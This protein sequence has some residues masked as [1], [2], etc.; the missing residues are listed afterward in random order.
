MND[1]NYLADFIWFSKNKHVITYLYAL[2][3]KRSQY[4]QFSK[5]F[6]FFNISLFL[7]MKQQNISIK[8]APPIPSYCSE[9]PDKNF[10]RSRQV[11]HKA[12]TMLELMRLSMLAKAEKSVQCNSMLPAKYGFAQKYGMAATNKAHEGTKNS[13]YLRNLWNQL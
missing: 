4:S 8:I 5:V 3:L 2:R 11:K 13:I 1:F 12:S 7:S 9:K 10:T 6:Q